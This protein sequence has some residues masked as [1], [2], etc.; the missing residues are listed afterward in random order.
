MPN[1]VKLLVLIGI[2][3]CSSL[4]LA[5]EV[6]DLDEHDR[7]VIELL[8]RGDVFDN[9]TIIEI[10]NGTEFVNDTFPS[11]ITNATTERPTAVIDLAQ[12]IEAVKKIYERSRRHLHQFMDKPYAN[13]MVASALVG[14][15]TTLVAILLFCFLYSIST[16]CCSRRRKARMAN[17]N[18]DDD[19][20]LIDRQV[21]N[22]A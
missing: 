11:N 10:F 16:R 9:E 3:E 14:V 7:R 1:V 22:V 13:V 17:A 12:P 4:V 21:T 8:Q 6:S 18:Y 20:T 15:L 2:V 19:Q 5:D